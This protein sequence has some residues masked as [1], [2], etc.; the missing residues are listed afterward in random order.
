MP[1]T[2]WTAVGFGGAMAWPGPLCLDTQLQ[3]LV[4]LV[5]R[6]ISSPTQAGETYGGGISYW[7]GQGTNLEATSAMVFATLGA[8]GCTLAMLNQLQTTYSPGAGYGGPFASQIRCAEIVAAWCKLNGWTLE[9]PCVVM[10]QGENDYTT[11]GATYLAELLAM[12]SQLNTALG[13]ILTRLGQTAPSQIKL[14]M[15]QPSSWSFYNDT[16]APNV[17]EQLAAAIGWPTQFAVIG[18]QYY[19]DNYN[20][21]SGQHQTDIGYRLDGEWTG[22]A[23]Q[24]L[25]GSLATEALYATAA[26][27]SGTTLTITF[28]NATQLV[29]DTSVVS[30]PN[31]QW[32]LRVLDTSNGNANVALSGFGIVGTNQIQCTMASETAGHV[33]ML[34]IADYAYGTLGQVCGPTTSPRAPIRDS[35]VDVSSAATGN[36]PMVNFAC[37][38]QLT[39]TGA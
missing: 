21:A 9:I 3:T 33:Y 38:Q 31:G 5:E 12:Q 26:S 36:V 15:M 28:S 13:N 24:K 25:R 29:H 32:G 14:L 35:A 20:S 34:G 2:P 37:H 19:I 17:Y 39:F 30:D 22:R 23:I 16:T 4:P 11:S 8:G 1:Y 6:S 18:P 7:L 27:S 10:D